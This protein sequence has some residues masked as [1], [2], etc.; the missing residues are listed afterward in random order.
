MVHVMFSCVELSAATANSQPQKDE[1][2]TV[3]ACYVS[4][5]KIKTQYFI[6][7]CRF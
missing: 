2:F 5:V 1:R 7:V 4:G 6:K 3:L